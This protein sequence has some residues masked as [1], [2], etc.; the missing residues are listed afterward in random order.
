LKATVKVKVSLKSNCQKH[1]IVH[2]HS[3]DAASSSFSNFF[4]QMKTFIFRFVK[5]KP[6]KKKESKKKNQRK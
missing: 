5:V 2:L 4:I 3:R 1:K 6:V